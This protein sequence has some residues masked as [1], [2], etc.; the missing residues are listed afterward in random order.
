MKEVYSVQGL[1]LGP[2]GLREV[3]IIAILSVAPLL[4]FLGTAVSLDGP[5]FIAVAQRILETPLDPYGFEMLWDSSSMAAAEFNR[6][7]PLLSYYLAP[8]IRVFGENEL[9]LHGAMLVFPLLAALSF[10]GIAR[11]LAGEGLAPAALLVVTPAF[12]VLATTFLLDVPVLAFSLLAVYALLRGEEQVG[13][14]RVSW[15]VIGGLAAAAAG[16]TKYV[17]FSIFPLLAAGVALLHRRRGLSTLLLVGMPLAVWALWGIFTYRTYG[18]VHFFAAT[19]VLADRSFESSHFLN[20]LLSTPLYYGAALL[21]PVFVWGRS[22]LP[23]GVGT[24]VAVLGVLLGATAATFILPDGQPPRR[25][26]L[27]SDGTVIA[28]LGI[29]GGFTT[30]V[31]VLDPRRALEGAVERFLA[32]WLGGMLVFTAFL[33]WHVN[34]AYALLAAPPALLLLF[35]SSYLRPG[36]P[37]TAVW[38]ACILA[39]SLLLGW[40]E[41]LQVNYYRETARRIAA[42]IGIQPG[43][44]WFVGHWGLQHYLAREGFEPIL[45]PAFGRSE[46]APGDWV[47]SARNVSQLDVYSTLNRYALRAV[48]SWKLETWLPLRTTNG[49][50]GAGFYSHHSGYAPFAWTEAPIENITLGRVTGVRR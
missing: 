38:V 8:W 30:W 22:F 44:R 19:D 12:L 2:A 28:A 39:F 42:E 15:L 33:N 9:A 26:P 10:F 47:V 45:P 27:G 48:W 37:A 31:L 6:N 50:A 11:R 1:A 35:R 34:A 14:R 32:L 5:V 41:A 25:I 3:A 20:K 18:E 49:D 29:A 46:L 13:A 43:R 21:F 7:P 16:L 24:E 36:K 17:G 40:A 23:R 4:P